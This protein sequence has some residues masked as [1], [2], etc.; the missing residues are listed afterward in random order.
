MTRFRLPASGFRL[1]ASGFRLPASGFRLPALNC[2]LKSLARPC[3]PPSGLAL[4]G[5]LSCRGRG[6]RHIEPHRGVRAWPFLAGRRRRTPNNHPALRAEFLPVS[7][8]H[9][10]GESQVTGHRFTADRRVYVR[11]VASPGSR[12][13]RP[14]SRET[15]VPGTR[16]LT[17][18]T[19]TPDRRPA[20]GGLRRRA[21][22]RWRGPSSLAARRSCGSTPSGSAGGA[23]PRRPAHRRE[24]ANAARVDQRR[25]SGLETASTSRCSRP[26]PA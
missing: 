2:T 21:R 7:I 3:Q 4:A 22:L 19:C 8:H 17:S 16:H 24:P 20:S 13:S 25:M 10:S 5:P 14:R 6:V 23:P 9:I 12:V 1:P 26:T 18:R 15:P 11:F